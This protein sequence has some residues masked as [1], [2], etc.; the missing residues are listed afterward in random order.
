VEVR[1][2]LNAGVRLEARAEVMVEVRAEVRAEARLARAE[3]EDKMREDCIA[4][5]LSYVI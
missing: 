1:A 3:G 2:K 4:F 5:M